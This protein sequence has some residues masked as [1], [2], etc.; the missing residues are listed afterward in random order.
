MQHLFWCTA[1]ASIHSTLFS[2]SIKNDWMNFGSEKYSKIPTEPWTQIENFLTF[3]TVTSDQI[4]AS[5]M[6]ELME[7][8]CVWCQMAFHVADW[9]LHSVFPLTRNSNI[10]SLMLKKC[11]SKKKPLLC[12]CNFNSYMDA[13]EPFWS[14]YVYIHIYTCMGCWKCFIDQKLERY[15]PLFH[16]KY[17]YQ[18]DIHPSTILP[19][20]YLNSVT[21]L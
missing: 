1:N 17:M 18:Y 4:H 7:V 16:Y 9:V 5:D 2:G 11:C 3:H 19:T 12:R 14:G 21:G 20:V 15:L 6:C 10:L 13:S 8:S